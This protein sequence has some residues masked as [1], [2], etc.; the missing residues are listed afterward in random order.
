MFLQG[1][2]ATCGEALC[3]ALLFPE[4]KAKLLGY[5]G[6]RLKSAPSILKKLYTAMR[7]VYRSVEWGQYSLVGFTITSEQL[8]SS[9]LFAS[10]LK[11][12]FPHIKVLF[13]GHSA[14]GE[15][16]VSVLQLFPYVD[17]CIDG[18]GEESFTSLLAHLGRNSTG[19][20]KDIP[21]LI[22]RDSGNINANPRKRLESLK[23]L[24]DPDYDHYFSVLDNDPDIADLEM[25][26]FL[27]IEASR[28]CPFRCAFCA[29]YNF[30]RGYRNRPAKEVAD[31]VKRLCKRYRVNVVRFLAELLPDEDIVEI[32]PL[33]A[34]HGIDYK[35]FCEVRADVKKSSLKLM[36]SAG[37]SQVQIGLEAMSTPLLRKMEKGTTAIQNIAAMKYC[38]ELGLNLVSNIMI[39]FPTESQRNVDESIKTMKYATAFKPP[40][41]FV[42]FQLRTDSRTFLD[43]K[44][45][46]ISPI[47]SA[48]GF[49]HHLPSRV[50]KGIRLHY[51]KFRTRNGPCNYRAFR[52]HIQKWNISYDES[53]REGKPLLC[54]YDFHDYLRIEDFRSGTASITIDGWTRDLYVFCDTIRSYDEIRKRFRHVPKRELKDALKRL[55]SLKLMYSEDGGWLS[56]AFRASPENRRHM[57]AI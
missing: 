29:N 49:C 28:G 3:A 22:Y 18:E 54:Y 41:N 7:A 27:P 47:E 37:V 26:T 5:V 12:D 34:S 30:W 16:G 17:L 42:R 52:S 51:K 4:S 33:L 40:A 10:W 48:F 44:K 56:L 43:P 1:D 2:N 53:R 21:G 55:L 25:L 36:K 9:L 11:R 8:F 19:F 14:A 46:G 6:K 57:P 35:F 24:P 31:S 38:E 13:G 50:K 23:R 32:F 20:E 39:G 15:V 45:Y